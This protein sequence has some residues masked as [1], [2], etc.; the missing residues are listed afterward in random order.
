KARSMND[1]RDD[2]EK[3]SAVMERAS[4]R[5]PA[6]TERASQYPPASLERSSVFPPSTSSERHSSLPPG[7]GSMRP[8]SRSV[9]PPAEPAVARPRS[10]IGVIGVSPG[11][12]NVYGVLDRIADTVCTV[13]IT[14]E[15]GTGKE[16]VARGL[17]HASNR[18]DEPFVAV[19]CG[20][21]PEA[22]L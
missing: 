4:S 20:A 11:I 8:A 3:T 6:H 12:L 2:D 21:I 9:R 5:P 19:N 7:L 22:L 16:L 13:L 14:G 1:P 10:M 15:S 18:A 17:H